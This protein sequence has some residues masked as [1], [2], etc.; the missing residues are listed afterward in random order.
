MPITG[1]WSLICIFLNEKIPSIKKLRN[2]MNYTSI[3]LNDH[4]QF[5]FLYKSELSFLKLEKRRYLPYY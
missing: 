3:F 5:Y 1:Q 4:F 2:G